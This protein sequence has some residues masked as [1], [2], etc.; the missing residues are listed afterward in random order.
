MM[1]ERLPAG[2]EV[3]E[4]A[5]LGAEVAGGRRLWCATSRRGHCD[6]RRWKYSVGN[7]SA[8]RRS[9]HAARASD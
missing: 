3:G 6:R 8:R 1:D 9:S 5:E 2:V 4:E 7:R